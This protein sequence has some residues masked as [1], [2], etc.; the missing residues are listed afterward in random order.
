MKNSIKIHSNDRLSKMD[1]GSFLYTDS[2]GETTELHN[3]QSV[4][5]WAEEE[6]VI[7]GEEV[8]AWIDEE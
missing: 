6:G 7:L 2:Y 1:D 3:A 4:R 8:E 5:K